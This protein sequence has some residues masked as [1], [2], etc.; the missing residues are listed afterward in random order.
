MHRLDVLRGCAILLMVL[1]HVLAVGLLHWGW[2]PGWHLLRVTVTRPAMPIFML[3]AGYL[4]HVKAD[5]PF[6]WVRWVQLCGAASVSAVVMHVLGFPQPDI[7]AVFALVA[8]SARLSA[9]YPLTSVVCGFSQAFYLPIFGGAT[10]EPGHILG[11]C[12]VGVLWSRADRALSTVLL[13]PPPPDSDGSGAMEA[14]LN[15]Q[16]RKIHVAR[17]SE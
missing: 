9:S 17:V 2:L 10:Y 16:S 12:A 3:V 15:G 8:L 14:R 11:L 13:S 7:L 4:W 1:D 6:P 5:N